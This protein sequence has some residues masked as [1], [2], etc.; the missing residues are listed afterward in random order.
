[1]FY[2]ILVGVAQSY[3]GNEILN[4]SCEFDHDSGNIYNN[5]ILPYC[6]GEEFV[7]HGNVVS[8][9]TIKR[10][11]VI[12]TEMDI[13]DWLKMKR[14]QNK[15]MQYHAGYIFDYQQEY[16]NNTT[17]LINKAKQEIT[18]NIPSIGKNSFNSSDIFIVHGHD[19]EAIKDIKLYLK[20]FNLNPIILREQVSGGK[21][22][23]EKIEDYTEVGYGIVLYTP[24]D[25]GFKAGEL[26]SKKARARQNVVF[27]HGYLIGKLGRD[28]V[29]ALV[30]GAVETP[31]DIGGVV[32]I[33]M[34]VT[35]AWKMSLAK[36]I[37]S[38][39]YNIDLNNLM[40]LYESGTQG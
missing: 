5:F 10:L 8:K 36:E 6:K 32:Y 9:N 40:N 3:D 24:C 7:I 38:A 29:S 11:L 15:S 12:S 20:E 31:G 39:G 4:E 21:T 1:M 23:I 17:E 19:E 33:S 22:I 37:K 2:H 13:E 27:E 28:K 14:E 18:D 26:E 34:N 16:I 25:E 35:E 30:K